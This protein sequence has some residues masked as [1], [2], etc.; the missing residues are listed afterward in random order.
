[1]WFLYIN[2][3]INVRVLQRVEPSNGNLKVHNIGA[4][5]SGM[6]KVVVITAL[7]LAYIINVHVKSC[8]FVCI[9]YLFT[10]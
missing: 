9:T 10:I 2:I 7:P 1:M 6:R 3:K 4:I 5:I 8:F